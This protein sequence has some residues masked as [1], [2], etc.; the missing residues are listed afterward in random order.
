[1]ARGDADRS[2]TSAQSLGFVLNHSQ[3]AKTPSILAT[4]STKWRSECQL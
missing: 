1:M 4:I 3:Q 2:R